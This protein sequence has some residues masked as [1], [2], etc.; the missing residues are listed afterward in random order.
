MQAPVC[1]TA[2]AWW[3]CLVVAAYRSTVLF[4]SRSVGRLRGVLR[5]AFGQAGLR[6]LAAPCMACLTVLQ[7]R[8]CQPLKLML[9]IQMPVFKRDRQELEC[10]AEVQWF[11]RPQSRDSAIVQCLQFTSLSCSKLT[12]SHA[13]TTHRATSVFICALVILLKLVPCPMLACVFDP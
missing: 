3:R 11:R 7:I 13:H 8:P 6:R 10:A 12:T 4:F 2:R 1:M 5:A 9:R